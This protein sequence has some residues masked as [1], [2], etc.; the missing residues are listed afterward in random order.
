M[1]QAVSVMTRSIGWALFGVIILLILCNASAEPISG[2][3]PSA[4]D[5]F[6][7]PG[8][9]DGG[10][11]AAIPII[12]MAAKNRTMQ[13]ENVTA[14]STGIASESMAPPSTGDGTR[15]LVR[16]NT[17]E[18][19]ILADVEIEGVALEEDL[20]SSLS[21]LVLY[22]SAEKSEEEAIKALSA[23]PGVLY[24]EPDYILSIDRTSNDPDLWR[25][26]GIQNTGQVFKEGSPQ[27]KAG[28]DGKVTGAWDIITSSGDV[29]VAVLDT[30]VDYTHPDLKSNMWTGP[31]GEHG[32]NVI[33]G[34]PDPMD[35]NGH[36]THCA[37]IIGAAGD[38]GTG[39]SGIAWQT[40]LMAVKAIGADGKAY[41][42]DII[43]G[44]EYAKTAGAD[45][46]SCSFG[47]PEN[48]QV[49]YETI[50]GTPALFICAAGNQAKD[51]DKV[52]HYPSSYQLPNVIGVAATT[53]SDILVSSSNYGTS[54][55]LAAPGGE[56]YSTAL[57]MPDGSRYRYMT[58]TSQATA[59][60]AGM[61]ALIK[62]ADKSL[63][64][65]EIRT[66]MITSSDAVPALQ[67]KVAANGRV[68][69]TAALAGSSKEGEIILHQGWNFVS[70]PRP[71]VLGKDT[72]KI[73]EKVSSGGHSLL[74]YVHNTGWKTLKASDPISVMTGYWVYSTKDD[75][76]PL[77]YNPSPGIVKKQVKGG[78]NTWSLPLKDPVKAKTALSPIQAVWKYVVG[79]DATLQQYDS[80][81]LNGGSGDQGDERLVSPYKGYWLYSA[82]EGELTG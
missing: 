2:W 54:V 17:S 35:D 41:T 24:A 28:S 65:P 21:G 3:H 73:F 50:S 80:P 56:M 69:L 66:L 79:Y 72:A 14:P 33:A 39:G 6:N 9:E 32:Y 44:I 61:A 51:N 1:I 18:I 53:A 48:S 62:N 15:I 59:F 43:K 36:G 13:D 57:T 27:G 70:V 67:G 25:Q 46:I 19:S 7:V 16:Y 52:P 82:G 78:W 38:N 26:W 42:S 76:V 60:V 55:H 81:I 68:N 5:Y 71:L 4:R 30:G 11:G 37:G 31:S 8:E 34:N 12:P 74:E 22:S 77:Q 49:L 58:G 63:T 29:I 45:I 47:G 10:D 75:S 64:N 40:K 23:L 20:S